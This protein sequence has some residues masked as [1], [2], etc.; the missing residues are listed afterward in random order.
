MPYLI[1]LDG[2]IY[3]GRQ[4]LPHA[5]DFIRLLNRRQIPYRFLT[6]APENHPE[7]IERRLVDMGVPA[8]P[9]TVVTAAMLAVDCLVEMALREP[10]R[11]VR[12]LGDEYLKHL[13][14]DRGFLLDEDRPD[15]VLVSFAR[16]ITVGEIQD[17]SCQIREGARFIATNPDDQIP[18]ERGLVPHTGFIVETIAACSG[19]RPVMAGKPSP[20]L[21]GRYLTIFGCRPEQIVVVGDRLDTDMAFARACG[22]GAYLMLTGAVSRQEA[23]RHPEAYDRLFDGLDQMIRLEEP[24]GEP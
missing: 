13:V 21:K 3:C 24:S 6:N 23:A 4:P 19:V 17:A 15:C 16:S 22:F 2:T 5:G 14:Q 9:G 11:R 8:Q 10:V 18:S 20:A 12:V 7:D 1:D